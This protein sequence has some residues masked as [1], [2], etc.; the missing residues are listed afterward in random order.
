MKI[1]IINDFIKI[2]I[3]NGIDNL[4]TR[5]NEEQKCPTARPRR[6]TAKRKSTM[7]SSDYLIYSFNSSSVGIR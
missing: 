1:Q 7:P 2:G 5:F 6:V 4:T 3:S